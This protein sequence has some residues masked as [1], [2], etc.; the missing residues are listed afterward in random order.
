MNKQERNTAIIAALRQH[1]TMAAAARQ[2]GC[3]PSTVSRLIDNDDR[4]SSAFMDGIAALQRRRVDQHNERVAALR[5]ELAA[6]LKG[7]DVLRDKVVNDLAS[8]SHDD[9][10]SIEAEIARVLDGSV[11][12]RRRLRSAMRSLKEAERRARLLSLE[13][14]DG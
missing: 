6:A 3:H 5:K 12:E 2:V 9:L 14:D 10:R 7:V 1:G 11:T 8:L 13:D 4:A